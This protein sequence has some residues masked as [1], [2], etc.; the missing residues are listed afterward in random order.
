MRIRRAAAAGGSTLSFFP[1]TALPELAHAG[2]LAPLPRELQSKEDLDWLDIH[3]GLREH[4]VTLGGKPLAVPIGSPPLLCYF[5][6]DLLEKA[7]RSPP[8][9]WDDYTQL[10][11]DLDRWTP[12]LTAVEPWG[13]EFRATMFLARAI[14]SARHP[15]NYSLYFDYNDAAPLQQVALWTEAYRAFWDERFDRLDGYLQELQAQRQKGG[16]H[17]RRRKRQ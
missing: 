6:R 10:V 3:A 13:K 5:R 17:A 9:T 8:E 11:R 12:G 7:G 15:G 4:V 2:H 1:I 16:R 14:A